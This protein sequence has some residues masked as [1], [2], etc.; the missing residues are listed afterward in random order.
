M[1]FFRKFLARLFFNAAV[2]QRTWR[3]LAAQIRNGFS[4]DQS[5]SQFHQRA[6]SRRSPIALVFSQALEFLGLG[7]NFGACITD[8]ASQEEIMLISSGQQSGK[9][10]EGL[11]LAASLLSARRTI[12]KAISG[13]LVY[14]AFLLC[15]CGILLLIV[16]IVVMP[17]LI[18][19]SDPSK[20]TGS[21]W[22]LYIM[23]SFVVSPLGALVI[24]LLFLSIFLS[25]LTLPIL[26]G[27]VRLFLDR[28]P[29]WSIYRLTV[30]CVWMFTLS[31]LMRSGIQLTY[32]LESMI[33]SVN[34][35]TYL[36]ERITAIAVETGSGKNL[37]E[38]LYDCKMNF[39]D[40]EMIDDLRVYSALPGF[41]Q[42]LHQIASEWMDDG[43]ELV[44][45]QARILNIVAI[46]ML[47]GLLGV[48]ASSIGSIQTQLLPGAGGF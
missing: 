41:Y 25:I 27:R 35:S 20:W 29:P 2:R 1:N 16:S 8:F 12:I 36:R 48:V 47:T 34:I 14:P 4:L 37:G 31:T 3:K 45:L 13:S 24:V 7:H 23:S 6:L 43:V 44:K 19:F 10:S 11:E 26:T 32:I 30:G 5:L 18:K 39:P 33:N 38:A 42:Q 9:L 15:M 28:F 40:L 22:I 46:L 17:E 21:A